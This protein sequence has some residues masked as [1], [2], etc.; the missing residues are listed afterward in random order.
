MITSAENPRIRQVI[1]LNTKNKERREKKV[2]VAEGRKLFLETPPALREQVYVSE[3][4]EKTEGELLSGCCYETVEDRLFLKMCDTQTPQGILTIA[5]MPQYRREEMLSDDSAPLLLLL[6][7][8][9]DPGNLGTILRTAEAA[10]VTG[11]FLSPRCAD[12]FQPKVIRSTMGSVFRVPFCVEKDL[13]E[14][15]DWLHQRK[16]RLYASS[17]AASVPYYDHGYTEAAGFMVGNEGNGLSEELMQK[18]DERIHI[19]MY[20]KVESLNA[21]VAASI[22]LFEAVRSREERR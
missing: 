4:F 2:F 11:V 21:A 20:G 12:L 1:R 14:T 6:E 16:V 10:G 8:I 3:S 5:R 19:P 18:A 15:A 22:L 13:T 7:D 9:Q 17:L